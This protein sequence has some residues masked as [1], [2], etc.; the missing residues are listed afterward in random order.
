[1]SRLKLQTEVDLPN[2]KSEYDHQSQFTCLG[3]CF[4]TEIGSYLEQRLF[5]CCVNPLGV[6][7]NPIALAEIGTRAID[8][9]RFQETEF[10]QK[11]E[12]WRHFLVHSSLAAKDISLSLSQANA[13]LHALRGSLLSSNLLVL[14]LGTAWAY[15]NTQTAQTVAHNHQLPESHFKKRLLAPAVIVQALTPFIRRLQNENPMLKTCLTVSPVR[16]LRDGLHENNLS[17]ASLLLAIDQLEKDSPRCTYFPAYELLLDE[18]RDY[19]FYAEDLSHPSES[20]VKHIWQAFSSTYLS[21]AAQTNCQKIE[22]IA[23]ALNH[24]AQ[25]PDTA[26][27]KRFKEELKRKIEDIEGLGSGTAALQISFDQLP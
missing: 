5:P 6:L 20:A 13:A 9:H 7:F 8:Q 11:G 24:R 10:F 16:H 4:A 25:H 3:S 19:R 21:S 1:M 18:L 12:L 27:Y 15:E 2:P 22:A 14:T 23:A 26:E 17:K